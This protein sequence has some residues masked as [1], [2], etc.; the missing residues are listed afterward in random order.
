M[1]FQARARH[2]MFGAFRGKQSISGGLVTNT[3][4]F[5]SRRASPRRASLSPISAHQFGLDWSVVLALWEE[6]LGCWLWQVTGGH[7]L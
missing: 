3:E 4:K 7:H 2:I 6:D 5:T 1:L